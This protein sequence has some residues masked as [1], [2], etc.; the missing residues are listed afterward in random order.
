MTKTN[1]NITRI[2]TWNIRTLKNE[3]KKTQ[4]ADD[5]TKF[6]CEI[7]GVQETH[8]KGTGVETLKTST[9][10]SCTLYY[11]G[12]DT[13]TGGVGIIIKET[14]KAEFKRINDRICQANI[15]LTGRRNFVIINAYTPTNPVS[16]KKNRNKRR[17]LRSLRNSHK[18]S[19]QKINTHDHR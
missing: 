6:E 1:N 8:Y 9:G 11:T 4:L 14:T 15:M 2:G 19:E 5:I 7:V 10:E 13:S 3:A 18:S 16:E 17:I 12:D